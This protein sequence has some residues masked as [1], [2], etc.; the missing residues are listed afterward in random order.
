MAGAH[1]FRSPTAARHPVRTRTTNE[2]SERRLSYQPTPTI[3]RVCRR[4]NL[5][6][7]DCHQ[8]ARSAP[9][10][11]STSTHLVVST[12]VFLFMNIWVKKIGVWVCK[13]MRTKNIQDVWMWASKCTK[14]EWDFCIHLVYFC[15]HNQIIEIFSTKLDFEAMISSLFSCT[16]SFVLRF[17]LKEL[18]IFS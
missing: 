12:Q 8:G 10:P 16:A 9:S 4:A 11:P 14:C 15:W 7:S 13:N 6:I 1:Q 5:A 18:L 17:A 3:W 2:V